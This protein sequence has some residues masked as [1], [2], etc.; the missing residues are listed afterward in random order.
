MSKLTI[1][2]FSFRFA[3]WRQ[4]AKCKENAMLIA[5]VSFASAHYYITQI[6]HNDSPW[7]IHND[8]SGA[9]V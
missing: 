5:Q 8:R 1:E 4:W 9:P 6:I 3:L 7:Y 2:G